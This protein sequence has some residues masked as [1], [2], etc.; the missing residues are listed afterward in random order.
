MQENYFNKCIDLLLTITRSNP[1]NRS[2]KKSSQ[3]KCVR[4]RVNN[5]CSKKRE[6]ERERERALLLNFAVKQ[7]DGR[8]ELISW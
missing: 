5:V 6:R 2:R 3:S 1:L 7:R 8:E 4:A